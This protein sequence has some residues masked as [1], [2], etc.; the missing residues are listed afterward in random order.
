MAPGGGPR[1]T[2]Y[3]SSTLPRGTF[4]RSIFDNHL[5]RLSDRGG[6]SQLIGSAWSDVVAGELEGWS[7]GPVSGEA[8]RLAG[9][10]VREI[11]RLDTL[12]GVAARASRAGLKNPD[13]VV[14]G[15][16]DSRPVVFAVDAKFSIETARPVQVGAETTAQ[17]FDTDEHL[18]RLLPDTP[19]GTIYLD[20]IFLSPDYSLTHAMF[21]HKVGHRRL[22]VS[23][24]DVV[25]AEA[26]PRDLFADVAD[27]DVIERLCRIDALPIDVWRSLLAAQYYF[28]LE[29]AIV[30]L[31]LD[32][33]RPLLGDAEV[34]ET[35]N[36]I[37]ARTEDRA[38]E[39]D[40][41]W[42]MIL[43]WD[44]DVELVRR[45]RQAIH[46][47]IGVPLSNAEL[48]D[49]ADTLMDGR[50]PQA[51]P[52]RNQVRKALG[53]RFMADVVRETGP[54]VPPVADFS[55]Q[56]ERVAAVARRVGERY[57]ANIAEIVGGI[58]D[59]LAARGA[60]QG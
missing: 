52:S 4:A 26:S 56:L 35:S 29:R 44:R 36:D 22:T 13:F 39:A 20:G 6:A 54:I 57:T 41:A 51:R 58:L 31:V 32:E 60:R 15:A 1:D 43:D 12:P 2:D 49:L 47:V 55:A 50:D 46:Q 23:R 18:T 27:L 14:F 42:S 10:V 19:N 40:S 59:D 16:R 28:R 33:R 17:L 11:H 7:G 37:R 25:L 9:T 3:H 5:V 34:E 21:R 8:A 38:G 30:G 48:R 45:Q 53:G 24:Q